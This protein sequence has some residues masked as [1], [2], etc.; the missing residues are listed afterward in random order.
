VWKGELDNFS[1]TYDGADPRNEFV[2]LV[3]QSPNSVVVDIP[4]LD[5]GWERSKPE[6]GRYKWKGLLNGIKKI[7]LTDKTPQKGIWKVRVVGKEVP[8]AELI[9]VITEFADIEMTMDGVC[10]GGTY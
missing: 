2:F 6:K 4:A 3:V 10:G 1:G 5:P 7:A 9:D 8:G